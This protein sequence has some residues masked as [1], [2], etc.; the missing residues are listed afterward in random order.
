MLEITVWMISIPWF[1]Q[2]NISCSG[3]PKDTC[4]FP[5]QQFYFLWNW[6]VVKTH[7][8]F[9]KALHLR[10]A[11]YHQ[12]GRYGRYLRIILLFRE[13]V[14]ITQFTA[15]CHQSPQWICVSASQ[16]CRVIEWCGLDLNPPATGRISPGRPRSFDSSWAQALTVCDC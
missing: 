7:Y 3:C 14:P 2:R 13:T 9:S 10:T 15:V 16:T 8:C 12:T 1:W 4:Q 11:N 6:G 5:S